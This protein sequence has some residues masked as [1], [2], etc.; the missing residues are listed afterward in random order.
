MKDWKQLSEGRCGK[1]LQREV[2]LYQQIRLKKLIKFSAILS[3]LKLF[4]SCIK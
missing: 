3:P 1:I 4:D 2:I